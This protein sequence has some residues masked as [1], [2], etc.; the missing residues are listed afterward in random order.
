MMMALT[1]N[2]AEY[3]P[4]FEQSNTSVSA[5]IDLYGVHDLADE[6][7]HFA[8][9]GGDGFQLFL[10][11]IVLKKSKLEEYEAFQK[12]SPIYLVRHLSS[13]EIPPILGIHGTHDSLVPIEDAVTF[14]DE[15]KVSFL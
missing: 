2:K 14:Y 3:Q 15:L 12:A 13:Q 10:E 5:C 8:Q 6:R 1:Q 4:G 9:K 7:A 11:R